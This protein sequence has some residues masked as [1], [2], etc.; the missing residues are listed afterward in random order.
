MK[1]YVQTSKQDFHLSE[2]PTCISMHL[3][4]KQRNPMSHRLKERQA[5]NPDEASALMY[6]FLNKHRSLHFT[7][8]VLHRLFPRKQGAG[9]D[10]AVSMSEELRTL[11]QHNYKRSC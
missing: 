4:R 3:N 6:L 8:F 1:A 2:Q 9:A 10:R 11:V 7:T 5:V